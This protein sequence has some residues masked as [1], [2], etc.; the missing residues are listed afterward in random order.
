M[1]QIESN[2]RYIIRNKKA[3]TVIDLSGSDNH[4][5]LG[6]NRHGGENQ[7]WE[8]IQENDGQWEFKNVA[9]GKYLKFD[10]EAKD[11]EPLIASDEPYGWDIW[12]DEQDP[13]GVRICVHNT[14]Q[15]VDLSD[16][17]NPANG[18]PVTLWWGWQPGENQVWIFERV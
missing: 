6:W 3:G 1:A 11:G 14:R 13:S 2:T 9:T 18:T 12:P 17:G 16:H 8:L 5:V 15:V 7:Q 4:S 10:G